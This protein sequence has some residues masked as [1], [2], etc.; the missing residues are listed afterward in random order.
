M[1]QNLRLGSCTDACYLFPVEAP[2]D[3]KEKGAQ[4]LL[5]TFGV[6]DKYVGRTKAQRELF[7]N[8]QEALN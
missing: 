8:L 4:I 2:T 3:I 6:Q 1:V 7:H 5:C